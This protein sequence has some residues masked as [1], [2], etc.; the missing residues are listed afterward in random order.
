MRIEWAP[1]R[2]WSIL[3]NQ[4]NGLMASGISNENSDDFF[5]YKINVLSIDLFRTDP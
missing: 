1:Y 5:K 4:L 2:L 3:E